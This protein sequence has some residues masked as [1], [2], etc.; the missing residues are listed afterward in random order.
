MR[1]I[2]NNLKE[3]INN[4]RRRKRH[5]PNYFLKYFLIW[6]SLIL[7]TTLIYLYIIDEFEVV[8]KIIEKPIAIIKKPIKQVNEK[9]I[10]QLPERSKLYEEI[11]NTV[12]NIPKPLKFVDNFKFD[13]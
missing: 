12:S 4:Y 7:L 6:I 8:N 1:F 5:K 3:D 2:I 10:Q 9:I 13:L 11:M